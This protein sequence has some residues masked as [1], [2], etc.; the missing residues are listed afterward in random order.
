VEEKTVVE[1]APEV[2]KEALESREVRL[3]GS[4]I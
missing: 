1:R 3:R 4:C 2:A